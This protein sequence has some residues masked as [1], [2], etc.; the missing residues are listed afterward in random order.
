[1]PH[2]GVA[3]I[4]RLYASGIRP[5]IIDALCFVFIATFSPILVKLMG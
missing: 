5:A 1:V 3:D 4:S 2:V